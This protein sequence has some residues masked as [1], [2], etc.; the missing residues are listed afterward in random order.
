[1]GHKRSTEYTNHHPDDTYLYL[2]T[3]Q[4]LIDEY[5]RLTK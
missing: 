4:K 3:A 5:N 2:E 1:L